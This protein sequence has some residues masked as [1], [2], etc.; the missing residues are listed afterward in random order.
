M[1]RLR[2]FENRKKMAGLSTWEAFAILFLVGGYFFIGMNLY[3]PIWARW[4]IVDVL[5][6]TM[7]EP[8]T[9]KMPKEMIAS[10]IM[11][12]MS[13]NNIYGVLKKDFKIQT[14]D[15]YIRLTFKKVLPS[16]MPFDIDLQV[17][18]NKVVE[19]KKLPQ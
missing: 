11:K 5:E 14:T 9:L 12:R 19:V 6:T 17:N 4:K 15:K 16:S 7:S 3:E 8:E 2:W 10:R 1:Q 13:V 18:I